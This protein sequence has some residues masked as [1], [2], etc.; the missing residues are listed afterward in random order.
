MRKR[1]IAAASLGIFSMFIFSTAAFA[2]KPTVGIGRWLQEVGVALDYTEAGLKRHGDLVSFPLSL[3]FGFDLR[4]WA[5]KFGVRTEGLLE[6][7]VE[8]FIGMISS[9]EANVEFGVPVSL[10]Y[11]FPLMEKLFPY[12]QVGMGP[13]YMSQH[14]YEQGGQFNLISLG[15]GGLIYFFQEHWALDAGYRWRHISNAGIEEPNAGIDAHEYT[16][17]VSYYF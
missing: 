4:P 1:L 9:P 12:V 2:Q 11:G 13:Y 14:T 7:M 17:G 10:K 15:G 8:P 3:R 5:E 16:L 6:L